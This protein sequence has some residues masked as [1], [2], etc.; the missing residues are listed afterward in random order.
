MEHRNQITVLRRL[1]KAGRRRG[2]QRVSAAGRRS[3]GFT[4]IEMMVVISIMLILVALAVP[5]YSQSIRHAREAVLKQDLFTLRSV[6]NQYTEDKQK[7]PQ[8]LDE[9]VGAGY[10]KQIPVDPMTNSNSS[11]QT[12]EDDSVSSADQQE[13]GI[14]DVKSGSNATSSEGNAYSEW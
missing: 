8:S 14:V 5:I 3:S 9:I 10:L 7:A 2:L 11:W 6:I 12:V 1:R 4:M 13:S